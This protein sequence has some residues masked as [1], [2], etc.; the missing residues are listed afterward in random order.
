[1]H[2]L[3]AARGGYEMT[4]AERYE[5]AHTQA[6]TAAASVIS[7]YVAVLDHAEYAAG[8]D[9]DAYEAN[10]GSLEG[11]GLGPDDDHDWWADLADALDREPTD[12]ER[13]GWLRA[14]ADA[15]R[16]LMAQ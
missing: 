16:A 5:N 2:Y 10:H 13:C 12:T 8:M 6:R 9:A 15:T 7:D 11:I 4:D 14:Y 1:M 3:R